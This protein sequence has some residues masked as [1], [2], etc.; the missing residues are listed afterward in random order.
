MQT[1]ALLLSSQHNNP[2]KELEANSQR[3]PL[4]ELRT[5]ALRVAGILSTDRNEVL[6]GEQPGPRQLEFDDTTLCSN[7]P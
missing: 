6:Q 1:P 2:A 4:G 5:E 7:I 3:N